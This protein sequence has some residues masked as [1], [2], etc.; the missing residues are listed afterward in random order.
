VDLAKLL[1]EKIAAAHAA[2][3]AADDDTTTSRAKA[4]NTG[5]VNIAIS[6]NIAKSGSSSSVYS[7]D[8]VTI[9]QRDGETH[10]IRKS[11]TP[12]QDFGS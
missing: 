5:G 1:R 2:G 9:I 12:P 10:V 7:D 11:S 8:D 3:E 6:A 4:V